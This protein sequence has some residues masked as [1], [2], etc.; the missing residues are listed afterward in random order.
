MK[1]TAIIITMLIATVFA[2]CSCQQ[3]VNAAANTTV[4]TQSVNEKG[5]DL[6]ETPLMI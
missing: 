1:K 2:L 5:L 4:T 6:N 3:K